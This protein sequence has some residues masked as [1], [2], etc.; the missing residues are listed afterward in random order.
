MPC[1]PLDTAMPL[2][3]AAFHGAHTCK[4][5][6]CDDLCIIR[7]ASEHISVEPN[8]VSP[9]VQVGRCTPPRACRAAA[10]PQHQRDS[11]DSSDARDLSLSRRNLGMRMLAVGL[12]G[13]AATDAAALLCTPAALAETLTVKDVTPPVAPAG[14]LSAR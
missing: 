7:I 14:P 5:L 12:A 10:S 11:T 1:T 2:D 4:M 9:C 8:A 6:L 13:A 3:C